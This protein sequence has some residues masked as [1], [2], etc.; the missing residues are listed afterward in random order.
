[1]KKIYLFLLVLVAVFV[2]CKKDM[3]VEF[4]TFEVEDEEIVSSYTSV[5]L[6]C[7]VRCAA[8]INEFYLQYDTVADFSTYQEVALTENEKTE[9]YSVKIGDLLDNTTYYVRYVAVNSYSQVTSEEVSEFKTL[10]ASVPTIEV[11]EITD[12]LDT[13]A[14]VGFV[15]KFNGGADVTKMGVCWSMDSVP[16]IEDKYV[17]C[18]RDAI[19]CV[20][21][22]DSLVLKISGLKANT[23]YYVRAYA[24]NK[25]GIGYSVSKSFV[26]LTLPKVRTDEITDIQ[27]TS[28]VLNGEAIFDG[29]DT[30][31]IYGF[32]WS[33]EENPTID[34]QNIQVKKDTFSYK[35]SN[36]LDETTYYV[37]VYAKN[38]IGIVYG[39]EKEFVTKKA[40][41]PVVETSEVTDITYTSAK[42]GGNVMS[43]G[44]AEVTERGI[45]YSLNNTPTI[46][47]TKV[48]LDKGLGSFSTIILD[49]QRGMMYYVRAYAINKKGISYG[50]LISFTTQ[51]HEYVDLGLSVKWATCNVG[52]TMPEEYGDYFAWGEVEPKIE[53]SWS[54]YKYCDGTEN[55]LTKYCS[56]SSFGKNAFTDN[57]T[58][59]DPED[60]AATVNW[61]GAWRMP[62]YDEMKEL[63]FECTWTW[64]TQ[65][66]VDGYKATGPNGNFIF[67]PATGVM[68]ENVLVGGYYYWSSSS[69][70]GISATCMNYYSFAGCYRYY[71]FAVR[72]VYG[73]ASVPKE[74]YTISVYTI[75]DSYG[76]V[77]GGGTYDE[78]CQ[79]TITATAN[80]GYRF[81]EWNDGN[82]DNP[83][84]ITVTK[85]AIYTAHFEKENFN[86]GHEYVDLGLPSGL[87]W[88]TCNVGATKPEEYGDYFAWGEVEPKDNYSWST[89]KYCYGSYDTMNKYYIWSNGLT[90]NK[91]VLDAEDDVA[92]VKWGG[93][94]RMPTKV[95]QDELRNNCLWMQANI[96]GVYGYK[97]IGTNGNSIFLPATGCMQGRIL[98]NVGSIGLFFSN[99]LVS[100]ISYV[101]IPCGDAYNLRFDSYGV[102]WNYIERSNGLVVRPVCK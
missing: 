35:L 16:T 29:N 6:N 46:E 26:S 43:D 83:R 30:T 25:M 41:L 64:T 11:R 33:E 9:V 73:K 34:N 18:S 62:T 48:V 20:S 97:V 69:S 56:N 38:K 37:R 10:Q 7:K 39:E 3:D 2:A 19:N 76:I 67:L 72:P 21:D 91:I 68:N 95:E 77:S 58:I 86:A 32:C 102:D 88:A 80:S 87:K 27:L 93:A 1:M 53:Y 55:T 17:E 65:N 66:G 47:D 84:V 75:E 40:E 78:G 81:K 31:T 14:T 8:T 44:G 57:K 36:L 89:Y 52:A 42:V 15:L 94:W 4:S 70:G 5:D 45:C 100:D 12:V 85:D 50:E 24:E 23:I 51:E 63:V 99:T 82:T 90:D 49:L 79:V 60:D 92:T 71:G 59:L 98:K 96:N 74:K 22:G 101:F 13:I 61:G 54:T 28:A